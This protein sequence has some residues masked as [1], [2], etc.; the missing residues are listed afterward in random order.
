MSIYHKNK[1]HHHGILLVNLGSPESAS[2]FSIARFLKN[3]LSDQR[4]IKLPKLLWYPILY[5]FILPFRSRRLIHSY[6]SILVD[7]K[8]PLH[9]YTHRL[10]QKCDDM[11]GPTTHVVSCYRYPESSVAK[12]IE[13][14]KKY[15]I[16]K[17]TIVPLFAQYSAS[18]S[19]SVFDAV[20]RY[21]AKQN[22]VW[23]LEFI[24]TYHHQPAFIQLIGQQIKDHFEQHGKKHILI[25]YHGLPEDMLKAGDPYYC[26]C[27]QTTRL[28]KE[29]LD[30]TDDDISSSFQ[31]RFGAQKWL[32]PYT[33]DVIPKLAQ[34]KK[35]IAVICPGFSVDC[36]ET[37]EEVN[38]TYREMFMNH[39]GKTY[40]YIPCLNDSDAHAALFAQLF[41][42][43]GDKEVTHTNSEN[44]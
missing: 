8:I 9:H 25:S 24:H 35:D 33:D 15:P 23:D 44:G 38:M 40:E 17:L 1:A 6:Q 14:L 34:E 19:A 13:S 32:E 28:I 16:R 39:G 4:V 37:I 43:L 21:M 42:K 2:Y 5:G 7:G 3:F 18:T 41:A 12:A 31:S 27:M 29:H 22:F 20:A 10:A 26:Y 30:L 11:T 36:L